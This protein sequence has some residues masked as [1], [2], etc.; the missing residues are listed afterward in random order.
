MVNS[1]RHDSPAWTTAALLL[2]SIM[3]AAASGVLAGRA[4]SRHLLLANLPSCTET[5]ASG[6]APPN[7]S[8]PERE[9]CP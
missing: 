7:S 6:Q 9:T 4:L 8:R 3:L 2:L 5:R 1:T